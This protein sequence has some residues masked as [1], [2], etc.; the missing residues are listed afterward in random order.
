[1]ATRQTGLGTS[2]RPCAIRV[3]GYRTSVRLEPEFW[4]AL[5]DIGRREDL[6]R[7]QLLSFIANRRPG[8]PLT[9]AVRVFIATYYCELSGCYRATGNAGARADRLA[10]SEVRTAGRKSSARRSI[11]QSIPQASSVRRPAQS[12]GLGTGEISKH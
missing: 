6:T 1:M 10:P 9:S 7:S 11:T 8:S 3:N 5:A 4:K 2:V 12:K